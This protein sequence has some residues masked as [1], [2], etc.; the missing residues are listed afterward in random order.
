MVNEEVSFLRRSNLNQFYALDAILNTASITEAA[1]RM[2]ISQPAMSLALK[3]LREHFSD[4]LV[5]YNNGLRQM[6]ALAE[7]LRPRV[8][9]LLREAEG[10]FGTTLSFDP[11]T[12][13]RTVHIAAP[14]MVEITFLPRVIR[15]LQKEAPGVDIHLATF[16]YVNAEILLEKDIDL[17]IVPENLESNNLLKAHLFYEGLSCMVWKDNRAIDN[18]IGRET[19]LSGRHAAMFNSMEILGHLNAEALDLLDRRDVAVRTARYAMLPNIVIGTDLIVTTISRFAQFF[20]SIMPLKV[21]P[22]PFPEEYTSITMQWHP[23]RDQEPLMRWLVS[24]IHDE[25]S[26]FALHKLK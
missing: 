17:V 10:V 13:R 15:R 21:L 1:T 7:A 16:Q 22:A 12:D 9:H 26:H 20:A 19:Y 6:T 5:V 25:A 14:D 24:V 18:N 4:E 2:H 3:K 11:A 8:R 23:H